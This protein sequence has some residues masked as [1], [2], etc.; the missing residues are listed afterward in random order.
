MPK[1]VVRA[2]I[3]GQRKLSNDVY[4]MVFAAPEI[5]RQAVPGQFVHVRVSEPDSADPLLRRPLSIADVDRQ[6]NTVSV[7]Y[8]VVGRGTARLAK[9]QAQENID[10]LG[11]LGRGFTL[12]GERPLLIGGGM[13]IAP[14]QYLAKKL[15]PRP[16]EILLGGRTREE[17]FWQDMFASICHDIHITTDDGSL[18]QRG[19]APDV[20]PAL[21]E[22]KSFD[23]IYCCGPHPMLVSVAKIT[24]GINIPCQVSLE[25]Y[26]A[27]GIGACLSCTCAAKDGSRKKICT[28]GPVFW[29]GEVI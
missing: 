18:G 9:L 25:E 12:R 21:L 1:T 29:A 14:L 20:L 5:A 13:G 6:H 23:M 10:C 19:V 22:Q 11:P 4:E 8:R 26:M 27:C 16:V 15:C 24:Q 3:A 7:I 2:V 28:D 17:I